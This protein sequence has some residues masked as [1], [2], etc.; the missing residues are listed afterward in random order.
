MEMPHC[1]GCK[2]KIIP[3]RITGE[4]PNEDGTYS[5]EFLEGYFKGQWCTGI[6]KENLE[7]IEKTI[8]VYGIVRFTEKWYGKPSRNG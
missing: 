1:L 3:N 2:V 6:N 4:S 7:L 5:L 8:R